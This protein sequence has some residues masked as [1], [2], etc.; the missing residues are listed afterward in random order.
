MTVSQNGYDLT[1][2]IEV[3]DG[4]SIGTVTAQIGTGD[5]TAIEAVDGEYVV[6]IA[7]E[8]ATQEVVFTATAL[9]VGLAES[10]ATASEAFTLLT[11][12]AP[13]SVTLTQA[14]LDI[15]ATIEVGTSQAIGT[16][17]ATVGEDDAVTVEPVDGSYSVTLTREQI[18]QDVTFS[19]TATETGLIESAATTS[20]ALTVGVSEAPTSV[21]AEQSGMDIVAT[22]EVAEGAEVGTVTAVI[23]GAEPV[24]IPLVG[25]EYRLTLTRSDFAKPVVVSATGVATGLPESDAV[26]SEE[27][28]FQVS[29]SPKTL[30]ISQNALTL[31][32]AGFVQCST[33]PATYGSL[34][35]ITMS[36]DGGAPETLTTVAGKASKTLTRSE[37]GKSVVVSGTGVCGTLPESDAVTR[38]PY[39][40]RIAP[41]PT[42][43]AVSQSNLTV[44]ARPTVG[45]AQ[46]VGVVTV[47]IDGAEPTVVTQS[48]GAYRVT[49]TRSDLGKSLVFT[50]TSTLAH[51]ADSEPTSSTP[52][53]FAAATVPTAITVSQNGLKV[54]A[55]VSVAT[56]HS[57]GVVTIS[58]DGGTPVVLKA[59]SGSF[60]KTLT[61]SELGKSVVFTATSK[62]TGLPESD[63]LSS[64]PFEFAAALS[65]TSVMLSQTDL[66]VTAAIVVP[67]GQSV[68]T[69]YVSVNG[70]KPSIV[71]QTAAGYVKRL[72]RSANGKS[73]VF[74]VTSTK[75]GKAVSDQLSSSPLVFVG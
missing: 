74:S 39:T 19:A 55:R 18:G 45:R 46:K 57:V 71:R 33:D 23:D 67:E 40:F 66:T 41:S 36:V 56:R 30:Y 16:V 48:S 65:P 62:K 59:S 61:R 63:S 15:I 3:A 75:S 8:D 49:L 44:I 42:K 1:V 70:G 14:G 34:G 72:S 53:I 35:T 64:S 52:Y 9:S 25:T 68:G 32:V 20:E 51:Y 2:N 54:S 43:I 4:Q 5:P 17:T 58:V 26:D 22:V 7:P 60:S 38:A 69:V 47:S 6:T 31:T 73:L 50:A 28:T 12:E 27:I 24:S 11:A 10:E 21:I 29:A 13:T 37:L